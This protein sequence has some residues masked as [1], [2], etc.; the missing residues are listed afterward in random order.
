VGLGIAPQSIG[1]VIG[2]LKAYATRVGSGPFPTEIGGTRAYA[3]S[4]NH[5]RA[6]EE[7]FN[8]DIND[9]DPLHQEIALRTLGR[10]YGATT[11]RLRRCGWLDLPLAKY[12]I[13]LNGVTKLGITKLDIL[14]TLDEI[15][16][17]IGYEGY[18]G[19]DMDNLHNVKG[20][21]KKLLGWKKNTRGLTSYEELPKEAKD[22]LSFI[23]QEL[24]VPVAFIST[25]PARDEMIEK[26]PII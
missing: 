18:D 17:C 20:I 19:V 14:D 10:E 24:G 3:W 21:Y 11:G 25:G 15:P 6:D 5:K 4:G 1:E 13:E 26:I 23:E 22:Y 12:A 8:Y 7:N 9:A 16:V 2:I